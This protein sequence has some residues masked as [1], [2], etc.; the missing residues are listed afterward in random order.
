MQ[1]LSLLNR[2]HLIIFMKISFLLFRRP[3]ELENEMEPERNNFIDVC[4]SP[5][6]PNCIWIPN[7]DTLHSQTKEF[8]I[9]WLQFCLKQLVV[10]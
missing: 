2:S 3:E 10:N 1:G 7:Y 6:S 5:S 4:P 8:Y 9:V